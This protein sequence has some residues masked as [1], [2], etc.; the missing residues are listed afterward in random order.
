MHS[1]LESKANARLS[2]WRLSPRERLVT[3]EYRPHRPKT[4]PAINFP[5]TFSDKVSLIVE[6]GLGVPY[7]IVQSWILMFKGA[8]DLRI[9]RK[10]VDCFATRR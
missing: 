3:S 7:E 5:T 4:V 9:T 6:R 10:S 2:L 1:L 8:N